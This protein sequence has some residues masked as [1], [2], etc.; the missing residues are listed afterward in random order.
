MRVQV[1]LLDAAGVVCLDAA[2]TLRFGHAGDGRL[3][4][5]LGTAGA[6]RRREVG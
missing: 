5:N 3:R 2:D 6:A 4:D 1:E